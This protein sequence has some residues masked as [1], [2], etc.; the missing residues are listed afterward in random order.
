MPQGSTLPNFNSETGFGF[1]TPNHKIITAK[2]DFA[3]LTDGRTT[4]LRELDYKNKLLTN[5]L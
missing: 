1:S 2:G 3:G 4:G 5:Y